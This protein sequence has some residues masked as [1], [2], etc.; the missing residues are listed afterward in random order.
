MGLR[1]RFEIHEV[2]LTSTSAPA[3]IPKLT[4][5]ISYI[6]PSLEHDLGSST[7][8]WALSPLVS[9]M[10][11]LAHK[12]MHRGSRSLS[13]TSSRTSSR[14]PSPSPGPR[15]NEQSTS[16]QSVKH[17]QTLSVPGSES[18][19]GLSTHF[20]PEF[21]P[22]ISLEDDLSQ[23]HLVHLRNSDEDS[24]SSSS[25]SLFSSASSSSSSVSL[26]DQAKSRSSSPTAAAAKKMMVAAKT[27]IKKTKG[28][29][30]P[31]LGNAQERQAY[32]RSARHR[33]EISF[34]PHVRFLLPF[35]HAREC[36]WIHQ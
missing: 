19:E 6:D 16:F 22:K 9:T 3:Q 35:P 26:H 30:G 5:T 25:S 31:H 15:E 17:Q 18:E 32:F 29:N 34:G 1:G 21:P 11:H 20:F 28:E 24:Y 7:Q 4:N 13:R 27:K 36:S 23:I 10:P 14:A 33:K 8:P 12:H 2:R